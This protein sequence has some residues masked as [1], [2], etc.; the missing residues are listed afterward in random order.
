[1]V[2][3]KAIV[4]PLNG[5]PTPTGTISF[6]YGWKTVA[7]STLVDGA[8]VVDTTLPHNKGFAMDALY[9]GDVNYSIARSPEEKP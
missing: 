1:M 9:L 6:D 2:R 4:Q 5:G 7:I 3:L 8:V